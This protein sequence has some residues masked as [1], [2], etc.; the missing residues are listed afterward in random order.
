MEPGQQEVTSPNPPTPEEPKPKEFSVNVT[1]KGL[2]YI[3]KG[4]IPEGP[5]P[6]EINWGIYIPYWKALV[7][8]MRNNWGSAF[9]HK[10]EIAY[11]SA[12]G[13]KGIKGEKE[14]Y[15]SRIRSDTWVLPKD[16][17]YYDAKGL[18]Q[19]LMNNLL[20]LADMK[21]WQ[22]SAMLHPEGRL[23][24]HEMRKWMTRKGFD[25]QTRR[26]PQAPDMTQVITQIMSG[27]EIKGTEKFDGDIREAKKRDIP[28]LKRIL[29]MWVRYPIGFDKAGEIITEEV[30]DDLTHIKSNLDRHFQKHDEKYLVAEDVTGRVVGMMGLAFEPKPEVRQHATTKR[31]MEL[32]RAYVDK[33]FRRG[34]GVGTALIKHIE[35]TARSRGAT[36]ILLDSGPRYEES[37]HGFYDKMGY[38][39]VAINKDYYGPGKDAVV[40]QKVLI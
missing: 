10:G 13:Q 2:P 14:L 24:D 5:D 6:S 1:I 26:K 15:I 20:T 28:Y 12:S 22:A 30:E 38:K 11:V 18:G 39:R 27:Q 9:D 21:G 36:E 32:V 7:P 8:K 29:E 31:P 23:D 37:G 33:D 16:S 40:W 17:R 35:S 19:F 25:G 4:N 34:K 3:F